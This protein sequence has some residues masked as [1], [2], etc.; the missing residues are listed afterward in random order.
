[1]DR[2]SRLIE[3]TSRMSWSALSAILYLVLL[4]NIKSFPFA[5]HFRTWLVVVNVWAKRIIYKI[6]P[7]KDIWQV[8]STPG[9]AWFDDLD[10]NNHQ[11]NSSYNKNL[12]YART[13]FIAHMFGHHARGVRFANAGVMIWFFKEIK[14]FSAYTM[15][16]CVHT[17]GP[18]WVYL[19]H[20]FEAGQTLHA[21]C[22]AKFVVKERNGK[23]IPFDEYLQRCGFSISNEDM[24]KKESQYPAAEGL[25]Q[26]EERFLSTL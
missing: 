25:I 23:T 16:T 8:V 18:K 26:C 17:W 24:K 3:S 20:R 22:L 6:P 2:P 9:R 19:E 21:F 7:S 11:N 5:W 14:P 13:D 15:K 12:D 10:M 4:L 1:M